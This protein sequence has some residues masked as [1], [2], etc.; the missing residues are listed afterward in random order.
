MFAFDG[1]Q[2]RVGFLDCEGTVLAHVQLAVYQ[3]PQVFFG[4]AVLNP[5]FIWFILVVDV[6]LT[7]VQYFALGVVGFVMLL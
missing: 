6:A 3:Y 1:D 7:Q 5:F 4:R 2:G